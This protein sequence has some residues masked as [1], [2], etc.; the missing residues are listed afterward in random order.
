MELQ[1]TALPTELRKG[2]LLIYG[3][4]NTTR[5]RGLPEVRPVKVPHPVG[6][7]NVYPLVRSFRLGWCNTDAP[8]TDGFALYVGHRP[9][10]PP[11]QLPRRF[12]LLLVVSK[13]TVLT[14]YTIG[15]VGTRPITRREWIYHIQVFPL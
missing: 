4:M 10:P 14:N 3:T 12:E 15:A 7:I 9:F 5:Q 11:K 2:V 1:S 8:N 13:T 6:S